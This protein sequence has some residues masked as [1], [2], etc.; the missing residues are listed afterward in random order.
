MIVKKTFWTKLNRK[1]NKKSKRFCLIINS[2]FLYQ[3]VVILGSISRLNI[4]CREVVISF[5][6]Y[7]I[8]LVWYSQVLRFSLDF[9]Q[10]FVLRADFQ[11]LRQIEGG[12]NPPLIRYIVS[13]SPLNPIFNE[14]LNFKFS[15][16]LFSHFLTI[17][18]KPNHF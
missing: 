5:I 4:D 13:A 9:E 18:C 1:E 6:K 17:I 8:K 14:Q 10:K 3:L 2:W 15:W 16:S 12:L 11:G 7:C